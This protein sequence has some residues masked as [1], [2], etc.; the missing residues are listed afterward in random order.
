MSFSIIYS[1]DFLVKV[2]GWTPNLTSM[3]FQ[4]AEH[5]AENPHLHDYSRDYLT[6]YKQKHPT[7]DHQ[8]TLYFLVVSDTEIFV[9]WINDTSCLHDTR[10]NFADPCRKEFERLKANGSLE[11]YDSG[12]HKLQFEVHPNSKK[13]IMCRSTYLGKKVQLNSYL[14]DS[15]TIIGHAFL[16]EEPI[17]KIAE[18]HVGLFLSSLYNELTK[19]HANSSFQIE[20][21]K[22]GYVREIEIIKK[23]YDSSK[24]QIIDDN[25]DFILKRI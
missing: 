11:I 22:Q 14:L 1:R 16:C 13:P 20:L 6:P 12:F 5:A 24:W 21:I 7:S 25:E 3:A 23:S 17:D 8:Y 19:N 10:A 9:T 15:N 18:I 4:A 2:C